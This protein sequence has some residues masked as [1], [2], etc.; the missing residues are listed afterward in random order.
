[1]RKNLKGRSQIW[2]AHNLRSLSSYWGIREGW[3]RSGDGETEERERISF[4][5][6]ND[7]QNLCLV[8]LQFHFVLPLL[9]S[10]ASASL[11]LFLCI[12]KSHEKQS[13]Q[14]LNALTRWQLQTQVGS[15]GHLLIF[16]LLETVKNKESNNYAVA[17]TIP[18][19]LIIRIY[20]V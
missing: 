11:A 17:Q 1:M 4:V 14:A 9:P 12:R 18:S 16:C 2:R 5:C 20:L 7:M 15:S 10:A 13:T 8:G 6:S 19:D 3:V